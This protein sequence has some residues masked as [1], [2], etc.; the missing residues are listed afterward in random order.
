MD[1]DSAHYDPQFDVPFDNYT[2][3]SDSSSTPRTPSPPSSMA[4]SIHDDQHPQQ[5]KSSFDLDPLRNILA[6]HASEDVSAHSVWPSVHHSSPSPFSFQP[7]SQRSS[8]LQELYDHDL[9]PEQPFAGV[10]QSDN[11][12][13]Q[14]ADPSFVN[15]NAHWSRLQHQQ[16]QLQLTQPRQLQDPSMLRRATFPYVRQEREDHCTPTFLGPDN[17]SSGQSALL[18]PYASRTDALYGEPLPLELHNHSQ[19]PIHSSPHTSYHEFND[20]P[21]VKLEEPS[22]I[23]VPSQSSFYQR[24]TSSS[25]SGSRSSSTS[26]SYSHPHSHHS[27]LGQMGHS[28]PYHHPLHHPTTAHLAYTLTPHGLPVQHT[29]D[30]ASKETQYLRRRC[31]NCHT[32]EPPSW[33][34]ST[35]NPGKIVCNKCGLYERTHLRPRPLRFDELRAGGKARKGSV[36]AGSGSAAKGSPKVKKEREFANGAN[37]I[38]RR[39]SVSSTTSSVHSGS[40]ANSDWDD[41]VSVHS[42]PSNPSSGFPSPSTQTYSIPPSTPPQLTQSPSAPSSAIR[43]PNAPLN[44][45]AAT[46]QAIPTPR[47][48]ATTP[49]FEFDRTQ[50]FLRRGSLPAQL[51]SS[52][53][54]SPRIHQGRPI[55]SSQHYAAQIQGV[56]GANAE[57]GW[58]NIDMGRSTPA[59]EEV[60]IGAS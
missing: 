14:S 5:F 42:S 3:Y 2:A 21:N 32:T 11:Y 20:D 58:Q 1:F 13:N 51:S 39:S 9:S 33:R 7:P 48:A 49:S 36:S 6:D 53:S 47:K 24:P 46:S 37:S 15:G 4:S 12:L 52:L 38:S 26:H 10:Q 25:S 57:T 23:I 60:L 45:I 19:F 18:G 40:G 50:E 17:S 54:G 43:L 41:S 16:Q 55:V 34:R 59:K 29:D 30:A 28:S 27:Q 8:L 56:I 35:L 22:H 44:D 31:F